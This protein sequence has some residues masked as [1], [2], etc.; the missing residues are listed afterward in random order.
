MLNLSK[1]T[2]QSK[3]IFKIFLLISENLYTFDH[4][5]KPYS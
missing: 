4:S 2:L 1:L 3:N 5:V